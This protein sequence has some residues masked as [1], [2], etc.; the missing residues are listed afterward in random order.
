ML[1]MET[2]LLPAIPRD[3]L[4]DIPE[5]FA[6]IIVFDSHPGDN[7]LSLISCP[8]LLDGLVRA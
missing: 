5:N 8:E 7:R 6:D 3:M 1:L 2:P 4:F